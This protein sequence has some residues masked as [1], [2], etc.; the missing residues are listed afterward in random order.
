MNN[1][2]IIQFVIIETVMDYY[3]IPKLKYGRKKTSYVFAMN[4]LKYLLFKYTY[5]AKP[6]LEMLYGTERVKAKYLS[7]KKYR[8]R[9]KRAINIL[10]HIL[11]S[12]FEEK[13]IE[14]K[15]ID[16]RRYVEFEDKEIIHNKIIDDIVAG[17]RIV[18]ISKKYNVSFNYISKIKKAH[19]EKI[20][21]RRKELIDS[22]RPPR[23]VIARKYL[24][25]LNIGDVFEHKIEDE[26]ITILDYVDDTYVFTDKG[27]K[28]VK[29]IN[30]NY[31]MP[32][33][34]FNRETYEAR[35]KKIKEFSYEKKR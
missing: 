11:R 33:K 12:R 16:K 35:Q 3:N 29:Y 24:T 14:L 30:K 2:E 4:V 15:V 6:K 8:N 23:V 5:Q 13:N 32:I 31:I 10:E 27:I 26:T 18:D 7:P 22:G 34:H 19:I 21:E 1:D 9:F 25:L 28:T 20:Y 17:N